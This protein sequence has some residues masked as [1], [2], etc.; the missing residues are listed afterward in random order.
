MLT[1]ADKEE[2]GV[3]Q[4]LT[5]TNKGLSCMCQKVLPSISIMN[6]K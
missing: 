2:E 6:D 5:I 3:R 1:I 4:M